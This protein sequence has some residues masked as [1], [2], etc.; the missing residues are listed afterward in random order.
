[1]EEGKEKSYVSGVPS[2]RIEAVASSN[3]L[4]PAPPFL[5]PPPPSVLVTLPLP[6]NDESFC[7]NHG[8][9]MRLAAAV[10]LVVLLVLQLS[11]RYHCWGS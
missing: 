10:V 9:K 3:F 6:P 7:G 2:F 1:M 4:H 8:D 5:P 11:R